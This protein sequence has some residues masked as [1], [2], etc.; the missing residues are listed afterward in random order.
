[1]TTQEIK[2]A[3]KAAPKTLK[4][5][6]DMTIVNDTAIDYVVARKF[7]AKNSKATVLVKDEDELTRI[8]TDCQHIVGLLDNYKEAKLAPVRVEEAA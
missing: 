1:M 8:Q 5:P 4:F 3:P 2:A 6:R 7:V